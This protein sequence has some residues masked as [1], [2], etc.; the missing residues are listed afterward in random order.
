M[1]EVRLRPYVRLTEV[2]GCVPIND[3][4]ELRQGHIPIAQLREFGRG[5]GSFQLRWADTG[6]VVNCDAPEGCL[7][8]IVAHRG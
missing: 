5:L 6:A 4:T 3:R 8:S 2:E 7:R 1:T